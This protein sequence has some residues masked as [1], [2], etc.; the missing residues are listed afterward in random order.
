[1]AKTDV[2]MCFA[3]RVKAAAKSIHSWACAQSP[4]LSWQPARKTSGIGGG[5]GFL[6][7]L[8]VLVRKGIF[9]DIGPVMGHSV[10]P[11]V[12]VMPVEKG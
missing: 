4:A 10:L 9:L 7:R 8:A 5:V 12:K 11:A 2:S 3:E 6:G 1:M